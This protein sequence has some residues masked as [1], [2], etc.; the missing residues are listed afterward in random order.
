MAPHLRNKGFAVLARG[1]LA[2]P[3]ALM[4]ALSA[5]AQNESEQIDPNLVCSTSNGVKEC[6][7]LASDGQNT[8]RNDV[9][10]FPGNYTGYAVSGWSGGT[11]NGTCYN[12]YAQAS[13]PSIDAH[14]WIEME[15]NGVVTKG[16]SNGTL[17]GCTPVSGQTTG[18]W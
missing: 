2:I 8:N 3:M 16:C 17:P 1:S 6:V 15:A 9:Q 12:A 5:C 7:I 4:L 13:T 18:T 10:S 14:F 11:L